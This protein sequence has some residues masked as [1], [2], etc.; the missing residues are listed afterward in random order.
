VRLQVSKVGG[1]NTYRGL[2]VKRKKIYDLGRVV[3]KVC[4]KEEEDARKEFI[5]VQDVVNYR[6][7]I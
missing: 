1:K 7:T 2:M 6:N 4:N 3:K 5:Y